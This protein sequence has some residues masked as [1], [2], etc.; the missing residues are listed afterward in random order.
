MRLRLILVIMLVLGLVGVSLGA[1]YD[2]R[3]VTPASSPDQQELHEYWPPGEPVAFKMS[4]PEFPI[5]LGTQYSGLWYWLSRL[6]R[7][8]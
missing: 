3:Q 5:L 1:R 8:F 4:D 2:Q 7:I 6:F